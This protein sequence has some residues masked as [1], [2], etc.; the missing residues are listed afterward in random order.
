VLAVGRS[1]IVHD[2]ELTGRVVA[3]RLGP[4]ADGRRTDLVRIT[5]GFISGRRIIHPDPG[6]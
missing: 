2:L 1:E 6:A 3:T 4:W 5:P